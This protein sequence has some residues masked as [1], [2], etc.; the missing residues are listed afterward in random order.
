LEDLFMIR[1]YWASKSIVVLLALVAMPLVAQKRDAKTVVADAMRASGYE[2]LNT[3]EYIGS[4]VGEGGV[5]QAQ[6]YI[7]G[8][9]K[10]VLK[11]YSRFIDYNA[12]TSQ[13]NAISSRPMDATGQLS[14]GGGLPPANAQP[15]TPTTTNIAANAG[16]PQRLEISLSPPAFLKMAA[17]AANPVMSSKSL[18]GRK[19]TVITFP[20]DQK[21]PSGVAYQLTGYIDSD[22]LVARVE[23]AIEEA[24]GLVGDMLVSQDY[25]FYR[26]FNGMKFPTRIVQ[27]RAGL[28]H[29]DFTITDAKKNSSAPAPLAAAGGGRGGGG[30]AAGGAG[31]GAGGRGGGAPAAGAPAAAGAGGRGGGAA[32]GGAQGA[33]GRG[34]AAGGA[35][36]AAGAGGGGGGR[37]GG[38]AAAGAIPPAPGAP[39]A[40]GGRGAGAVGG[41]PAA[42]A[43]GGGRGAAP[44]F[45][46]RK[47]GDGIWLITGGYPNVAIEFKDFVAMIDAPQNGTPAVIAEIK[48]VVPNKPIRYLINTHAHFDHIGGL[49]AALVEGP[50]VITHRMNKEMYE[51]FFKNPR[52]LAAGGPDEFEKSGK[53]PKFEYMGDKKVI[54]DSMNTV[55]LYHLK[56]V[57]H[58]E[59]MIVVYLPKIKAIYQSDAFNPPATTAPIPT[60][61]QISG[62]ERLLASELDRLKIDYNI[63]LSGHQPGGGDR[64]V[65]KADLLRRV[66]RS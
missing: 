44:T 36:A 35:P 27:R 23:T 56:G 5:G 29:A 62:F 42:Q 65:T 45:G 39:A 32:A 2:G 49:R 6:S 12:G 33:G 19:M 52:T 50:T 57:T 63:I 11:N 10:R 37:G 55:E 38:A 20:V 22:N 34:G 41:A 18:N 4:G 54:K 28:I 30:A 25:S 59:D 58:S 40:A 13:R 51:S 48:K 61:N 46:N 16:W 17:A 8:W 64:E 43:A 7:V 14:G 66:G 24:T 60:G 26:D 53:K 3:L 31:A 1:K 21:A 9:D 15:D 47:L